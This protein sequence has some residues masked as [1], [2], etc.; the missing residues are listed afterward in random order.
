MLDKLIEISETLDSLARS[1]WMLRGIPAFL[2]ETVSQHSYRVALLTLGLA[3]K[4]SSRGIK[5]DMGRAVLLAL[6]HDIAEAYIGDI[7]PMFKGYSV[8][9][10]AELEAVI[11]RIGI[12]TITRLFRE[13]QEQESV[14]ALIVKLADQ[15]ATLSKAYR[16]SAI[17]YNVADII[18]NTEEKIRVLAG[19]IGLNGEV[20]INEVYP[21]GTVNHKGARG[22]LTR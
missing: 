14:E 21:H 19:K 10:P 3:A 11:E 5:V 15:L 7:T 8:K 18:E 16:Y 1:G 17:G 9:E 12:D 2:S 6:I 20:L 13:Y 22:Q 4:M